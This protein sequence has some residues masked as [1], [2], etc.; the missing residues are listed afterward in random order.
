[1]ISFVFQALPK[2]NFQLLAH[3]FDEVIGSFRL[4]PP[5]G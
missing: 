4:L 5:N 3:L 2:D 1:M